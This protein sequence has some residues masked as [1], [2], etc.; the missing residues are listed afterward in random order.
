[1]VLNSQGP[2]LVK[3]TLFRYIVQNFIYLY[4]YIYIYIYFFFFFFFF[5]YIFS[6]TLFID[7]VTVISVLYE[8]MIHTHEWLLPVKLT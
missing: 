3:T 6:D 2:Q 7:P 4:I 5:F 8:W 1:M